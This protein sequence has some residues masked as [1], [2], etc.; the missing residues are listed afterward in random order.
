MAETETVC[1]ECETSISGTDINYCPVCGAGPDP[2]VEKNK[3]DFNDVDLP[4]IFSQEQY[5]DHYR[6]WDS[7]CD[8]AFGER[9][10]GGDIANVPEDM[11]RMKYNVFSVYYK[12]DEDLEI[13]GPFL[14]EKEA[15]D[16]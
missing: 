11:P 8:E 1:G 9:L 6:L 2:L 10:H 14:S 16:A 3:Y 12:L 5:N 13:H 7:F 4:I 15:H